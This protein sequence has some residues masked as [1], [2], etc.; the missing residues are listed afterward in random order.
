MSFTF[1]SYCDSL[2]TYS[3][4]EYVGEE[5]YLC[6][7]MNKVNTNLFVM[8]PKTGYNVPIVLPQLEL[9]LCSQYE[10]K[11]IKSEIIPNK[12]YYMIFPTENYIIKYN[13]KIIFRLNRIRG[14]NV[15]QEE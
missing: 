8:S 11:Y 10:N 12:N 6:I 9:Y 3:I 1:N 5:C 4:E 15:I 2:T 14:W 7:S 13:G